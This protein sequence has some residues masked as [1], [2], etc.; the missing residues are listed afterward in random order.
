MPNPL[1]FGSPIGSMVGERPYRLST[2]D[3]DLVITSDKM[4]IFGN[5]PND[6]VE[7]WFY[8]TDG[9][10]AGNIVVPITS[11]TLTL[12]SVIDTNGSYELLNIDYETLLP[13]VPLLPG[14]YAVSIYLLQNE[15]GDYSNKKLYI[16]KI[17]PSRTEIKLTT[18]N[19]ADAT[20]Q[21]EIYEFVVPS[22]PRLYAKALIDQFFAEDINPQIGKSITVADVV[23]NMNEIHSDTGQRIVNSLS[24]TSFN[25]LFDYIE[26]ETYKKAIE[27]LK[28]D[29][30][31]YNVQ[32]AE[33]NSYISDSLDEVLLDVVR[34]KMVDPR[35]ILE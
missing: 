24:A 17:S 16:D 32:S 33:I 3:Q 15:V 9:S 14:R 21:K 30:T 29:T 10:L 35:F 18:D 23:S 7:I 2:D 19:H 31:N 6:C 4:V 25:S 20:S 1:N 28:E 5:H 26:N 34:K 11:P 22:V 8:N 12:T 13:S 27:K